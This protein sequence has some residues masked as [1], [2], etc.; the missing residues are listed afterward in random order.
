MTTRS[1]LPTTV[2]RQP[3]G[4][5][6]PPSYR[7]N[8]VL[9]GPWSWCAIGDELTGAGASNFASTANPAASRIVAYPFEIA[10]PFLVMKLWAVMGTTG[11]NNN[12]GVMVYS[13]AG[14]NLVNS[15]VSPASNSI[16]EGNPADTLLQPGRYWCGFMDTGTSNT[17]VASAMSAALLRAA[18]CAQ[19][20][21]DGT[22]VQNFTPAAIASAFLPLAGIAGRTQVA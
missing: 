16:G 6:V 8:D 22:T 1:L 15:A 4:I 20:A 17:P 2:G 13:E 18:G 21:G 9:I 19:M 14:T 10:E 3:V 5:F 7:P 12:S 11:L